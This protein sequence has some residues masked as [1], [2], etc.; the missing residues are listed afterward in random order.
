[1]LDRQTIEL[2]L[3]SATAQAGGVVDRHALY[4]IRTGVAQALQ[5]KEQHRRRMA[6]PAYQWS[7]PAPP[8]R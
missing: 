1:M 4:E 3:I 7:K 2:A 5:A 8:R 6:A